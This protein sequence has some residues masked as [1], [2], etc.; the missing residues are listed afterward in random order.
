MVRWSGF[1]VV[2]ATIRVVSSLLL[3]TTTLASIADESWDGKIVMPTEQAGAEKE[4]VKE[5]GQRWAILV[6]GSSGYG[7][8]RHQVGQILSMP[9][10]MWISLSE[11]LLHLVFRFRFFVCD[12]TLEEHW[13]P[14]IPINRTVT[15]LCAYFRCIWRGSI[16]WIGWISCEYPKVYLLLYWS[17]CPLHPVLVNSTSGLLSFMPVTWFC[18]VWSLQWPC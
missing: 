2:V 9:Q 10:R 1:F 11:G 5:Q 17:F 18:L 8:Y 13:S 7:N 15:E 6:A 14:P 3:C 12:L 16:F 4:A